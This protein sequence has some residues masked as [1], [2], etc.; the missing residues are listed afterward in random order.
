MLMDW[1]PRMCSIAILFYVSLCL[2]VKKQWGGFAKYYLGI[3]CWYGIAIGL[4]LGRC[5]IGGKFR[6][7]VD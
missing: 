1:A 5:E 2:S 6:D 3:R 7:D 4:S